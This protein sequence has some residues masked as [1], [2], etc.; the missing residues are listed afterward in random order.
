MNLYWIQDYKKG[1]IDI[2]NTEI[3]VSRR[4]RKE[5]EKL[6]LKFDLEYGA[7]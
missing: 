4:K 2:G 1:I 7:F 6:Y 3:V 5:F